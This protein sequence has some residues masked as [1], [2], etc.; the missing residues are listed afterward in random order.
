MKGII[1][2][3]VH[4]LRKSQFFIIILDDFNLQHNLFTLDHHSL[5]LLS[6]FKFYVLGELNIASFVADLRYIDSYMIISQRNKD[7]IRKVRIVLMLVEND[8]EMVSNKCYFLVDLNK[9]FIIDR[10]C[11]CYFNIK[12]PRIQ[13][14]LKPIF[15]INLT[16]LIG[17][18]IF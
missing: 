9:L 5:V 11:Q 2:F 18:R 16:L 8:I 3:I 7:N 1:K 17:N 6:I 10:M 14:F 4:T 15:A 12:I 13:S